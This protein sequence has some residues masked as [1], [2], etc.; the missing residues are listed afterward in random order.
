MFVC[1]HLALYAVC[2]MGLVMINPA[3]GI[4]DQVRLKT[5][6]TATETN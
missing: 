5:V 4:F 2:D 3:F 6:G 1:G